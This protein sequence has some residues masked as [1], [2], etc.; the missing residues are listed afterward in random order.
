MNDDEYAHITDTHRHAVEARNAFLALAACTIIALG[1]AFHI[2]HDTSRNATAACLLYL[3]A[4]LISLT[5]RKVYGDYVRNKGSYNRAAE[6]L[7]NKYG[8]LEV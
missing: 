5:A 3:M 4:L 8:D 6:T 1:L 2:G 7:R